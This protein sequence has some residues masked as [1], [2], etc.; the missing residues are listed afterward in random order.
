[1]KMINRAVRDIITGARKQITQ[2]I[3][4]FFNHNHNTNIKNT[5][6]VD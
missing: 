6:F 3:D 2:I 5:M 4:D 1:M